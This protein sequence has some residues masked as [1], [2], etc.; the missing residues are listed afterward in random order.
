M[1][2]N[3]IRLLRIPHWIKNVFIFI[4]LIF[5]KHLLDHEFLLPVLIGYIT[6]SFVSSLVYV[7][8]DLIDIESDQKHPNKKLRP[9]ASGAVSKKEAVII[10]IILALV[11]SVLVFFVNTEFII[12]ISSYIIINILYTLYLKNVVIV[13]LACI[14]IGFLLR[15]IGGALIID[16]Y[17]SSW[18]ILTTMF[19]SVFLAVMKRRSELVLNSENETR[20]V[21]GE[22]NLTFIDQISAISAACVI[23]CYAIYSVAEK[24]V[25]YFN[26]ENLVY[27]SIF[28]VFGI[29]RYMYLVFKK[30]KGENPT[31]IMITDIP[32]I[33]N[34]VF[35][36]VTVYII[37]YLGK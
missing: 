23:L 28:V 17:I 15:V 10:I 3:Y 31:E 21:L 14:S 32:M 29:F 11:I 26:T 25:Q 12:I 20:K 30:S 24:T 2:K 7:F 18:L 35:Y 33:A 27:S 16:I 13:D 22:Y 4:P 1:I 9:L 8:N 34:L 37:I 5:S 6:F 19:I 36:S